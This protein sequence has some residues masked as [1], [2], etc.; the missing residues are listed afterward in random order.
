MAKVKN[1]LTQYFVG[2]LDG[3][4]E[5]ELA[6]WISE[7]NDSTDE[8]TEDTAYYDGDGT[9]ETEVTAIKLGYEFVGLYDKEDPAQAFIDGLKFLVGDGRKIKFRQV[10]A[11]G[12][13]LEG[14]ATVTSIVTKGGAASD[15]EPFQ[16]TITWNVVPKVTPTAGVPQG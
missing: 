14:P 9:T 5:F 6:K 8:S 3:A 1:A 13:T 7:V 10:Q 2:P 16:C 4:A 15:Y 12:T 11:D